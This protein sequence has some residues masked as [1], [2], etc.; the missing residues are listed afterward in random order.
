M[1]NNLFFL[2]FLISPILLIIGLVKPSKVIK[3]G[4]NK[5]RKK[6]F[7]TYGLLMLISF[8]LFIAT[9]PPSD[10]TDSNKPVTESNGQ[11][12]LSNSDL[13]TSNN[14]LKED[15]ISNEQDK[16]NKE[17][18]TEQKTT[19]DSN[20]DDS[21]KGNLKV[22]FI[23]VGQA[24]SIL[25]QAPT[26]EN[27][28]IDAGNNT[29]SDLIVNYLK[30]QGVNKL[31]YVIGTHPHE[32]HIGGLDVAINTFEIGKVIMPKASTTTK[33]FEDVLNA[34]KSK[35]L[36]ITTP[37]SGDTFDLGQAKCTILAPNSNTYEE[38]N[39]YSVVLKLEYGNTAFLFTGDAEDISENEMIN[40]GYNLSADVLKV[41]HHGSN[42]STTESFL[43]AV[44]PKYAVISV[45]KDNKYGHPDNEVLER[46]ANA[47]I[48]V[49][50]TDEVGTI[51]VTSD[52]EN[53][54]IDKNASIVQINVP[55]TNTKSNDESKENPT[56]N[57]NSTNNNNNTNSSVIIKNIDKEAE[58][59]TIKNN[60]SEDINLKGWKLVSVI[61][62]QTY[63]FPEYILKAGASVTISSGDKKGD[64]IWSKA[65]IWNNSKSDPGELYDNNGNLVFRYDD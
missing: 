45:G 4:K 61:G 53:I 58:I 63:T 57:D 49:Y 10:T 62:N 26:G 65:N 5:T 25:I 59:V 8:S 38:L 41:G 24:D 12:E 3:W 34:I 35:N 46:L 1:V 54:T 17:S 52:G 9:V 29:D 2:I 60:S 16:P 13:E 33:T 50:R 36:K 31:D 18:E 19:N 56:T 14:N 11:T 47:N 21:L 6:V 55:T 37:V 30:T 39:N 48:Q 64:L 22:H 23:D 28:L 32:D 44:S 20:D 27:M 40:K 15:S 51:L 43:K 7:I 42:T